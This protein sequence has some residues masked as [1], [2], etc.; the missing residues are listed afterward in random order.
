[1][2]EVFG[3]IGLVLIII[4]WLPEVVQTIRTRKSGM[5]K[6]FIAL[7]FCGSAFLAI[8][9]WQLNSVPFMI[10][11]GL[12]AIVPLINFYFALK[13]KERF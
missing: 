2:D 13:G 11:N 7:Y 4:A 1:M 3:I 8:Y 10:L 6:E 9:A 5:K 12:A